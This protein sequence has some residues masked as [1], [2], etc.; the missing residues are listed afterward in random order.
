MN[1]KCIIKC[2]AFSIVLT[3][4]LLLILA[5]V[6]YFSNIS[7]NV[8]VYLVYASV[9]LSVLVGSFAVSK[10]SDSKALIHSLILCTVYFIVLILLSLGINGRIV[11]NTHFF[12]IAGGIFGAGVLGTII[13]K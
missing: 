6:E 10:S 1:I 13:G 11:F 4:I 2:T 8:I 5:V 12:A 9:I 3:F 7:E